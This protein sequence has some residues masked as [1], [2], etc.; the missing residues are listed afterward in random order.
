MPSEKVLGSLG[1]GWIATRVATKTADSLRPSQRSPASSTCTRHVRAG[2]SPFVHASVGASVFL[3]SAVRKT[4]TWMIFGG[5]SC[6]F[7]T[8]SVRVDVF[9]HRTSSGEPD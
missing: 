8:S 7:L 3:G 9:R 4:M 1:I 6:Q 2:W 5:D